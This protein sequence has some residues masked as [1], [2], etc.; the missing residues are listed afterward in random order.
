MGDR[1]VLKCHSSNSNCNIKVCPIIE[2]DFA[3]NTKNEK[4][5]LAKNP[6]SLLVK[7]NGNKVFLYPP[8]HNLFDV[9]FILPIKMLG[10]DWEVCEPG[11][12]VAI[13]NVRC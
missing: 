7:L 10:H 13:Q 1:E 9:I 2:S 3:R 5:T 8:P 11:A 12:P 6:P 4:Y